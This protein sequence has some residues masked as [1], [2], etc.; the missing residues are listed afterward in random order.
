MEPKIRQLIIHPAHAYGRPLVLNL[1]LWFP[2]HRYVYACVCAY[3]VAVK[4]GLQQATSL[5]GSPQLKPRD[6]I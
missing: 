4:T 5:A 3:V 6:P 1:V 2:H